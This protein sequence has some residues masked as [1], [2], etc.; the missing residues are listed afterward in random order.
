MNELIK[1][2]DMFV[3]G[4]D[5]TMQISQSAIETIC[6]IEK[7]RKDFDK[8]YKKMKETLLSGME[9][10]GIKKAES[11]DLLITYVEPTERVSID[12]DKLWEKYFN[13]AYA[14][15]KESKVNASVRI[16]VR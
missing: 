3:Q 7:Q 4:K 12:T 9:E 1:K 13:A 15:Q 16:K 11:D 14:C 2:S 5:G 6:S 10:Y 8:A